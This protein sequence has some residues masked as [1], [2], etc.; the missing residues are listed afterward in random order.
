MIHAL[1]L[2]ILGAGLLQDTP[3]DIA[4]SELPKSASCVVCT[5]NGE[6]HG[7][8]KPAGGV[9][10]KGKA[11]YFCN[12]REVAEFK[13]DP[14][15]WMPPLLPRPA[16]ALNVT[17]LDGKTLSLAN[18]KDKV[19]LV[20]FWATW[21]KP[22]IDGMP[23]VDKLHKELS[24][25]G[26]V[27]LGVSIDQDTKKVG[28]FAAKKRLSYDLVLDSKAKPTWQAFNVKAIPALFLI[29]KQGQIVA[30]WKGKV[31]HKE[32]RSAVETALRG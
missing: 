30:Q 29:D 10:Y 2:T 16:P 6:T 1:A 13:K 22:C 11:Y 3:T 14:E 27:V 18:Y 5:Q 32:L 31:D 20:D 25:K 28:P 24:A 23:E 8:E 21:C 26:L 7:E 17:S 15:A 9:M 19:V 12:T 4:K